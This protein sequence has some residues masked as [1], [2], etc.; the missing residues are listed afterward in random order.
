M[1]EGLTLAVLALSGTVACGS[2]S[3]PASASDEATTPVATVE[4]H[5]TADPTIFYDGGTIGANAY[6]GAVTT[7]S[8][9]VTIDG[10]ESTPDTSSPPLD[11]DSTLPGNETTVTKYAA[12]C[13]PGGHAELWKIQGGVHIPDLSATFTT[14]VIDFLFAHPK[15]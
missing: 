3:S 7:V 6:P 13:K 5:G 10:C 12:G 8:D 11:L 15:P 2:S 1:R 14:D 4:I 9:W